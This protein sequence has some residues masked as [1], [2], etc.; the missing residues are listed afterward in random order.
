MTSNNIKDSPEEV[1][2][3]YLWAIPKFTLPPLFFPF[4]SSFVCNYWFLGK[5]NKSYT[6]LAGVLSPPPPA[7]A[8]I[9]FLFHA[10]FMMYFSCLAELC[11]LALWPFVFCQSPPTI[12]WQIA[13]R[14]VD[15]LSLRGLDLVKITFMW[16]YICHLSKFLL[17]KYKYACIYAG[18]I[19]T[20]PH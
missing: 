10:F 18:R 15:I 5:S 9:P 13:D 11:L 20:T 1:V 12:A 17:C 14:K 8:F 4:V 3:C 16:N 2:C 6:Y 7:A 19:F